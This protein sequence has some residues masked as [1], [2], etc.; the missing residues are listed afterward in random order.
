M[1]ERQERKGF[2]LFCDYFFSC[3]YRCSLFLRAEI[4]ELDFSP[5]QRSKM[6]KIQYKEGIIDGAMYPER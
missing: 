1:G 2:I 6:M 5:K 4:L 3:C